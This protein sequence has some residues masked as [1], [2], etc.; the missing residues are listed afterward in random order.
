MDPGW[1]AGDV[2]DAA[3]DAAEQRLA[4]V[5]VGRRAPRRAPCAP[6]PRRRSRSARA[7]GPGWRGPAP[8]SSFAAGSSS[9]DRVGRLL[10]LHERLRCD[11]P[12]LD[13]DR[14][15][16]DGID[17][18]EILHRIGVALL[19]V[20]QASERVRRAD[21]RLQLG[22]LK[23]SFVPFFSSLANL[24]S[25]ASPAATT[26]ESSSLAP[27][28]LPAESRAMPMPT[29]ASCR[30]ASAAQRG[31]ELLLGGAR[32][33]LLEQAPA[34]GQ[35]LLGV[36]RRRRRRWSPLASRPPGG[37]SCTSCPNRTGTDRCGRPRRAARAP[38]RRRRHPSRRPSSPACRRR[39]VRRCSCSWSCAWS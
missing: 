6:A 34:V 23:A 21:E 1:R 25:S 38:S 19:V 2:V 29:R 3:A 22:W 15:V 30:V 7:R 24:A 18:V 33:A 8:P 11:Q 10:L 13:A 12:G 9:R 20:G 16:V 35:Q 17:A 26:A 14:A 28:L 4:V 36:R 27:S 39:H 37:T 5:R 31:A 32:A